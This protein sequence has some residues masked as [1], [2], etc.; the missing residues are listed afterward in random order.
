[1]TFIRKDKKSREDAILSLGTRTGIYRICVYSV[2][3]Y[4]EECKAISKPQLP[5]LFSLI[6]ANAAKIFTANLASL[7]LD[8]EVI[9]SL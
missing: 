8:R 9:F 1:M 2:L 7:V 4:D 5:M 6:S 3:T